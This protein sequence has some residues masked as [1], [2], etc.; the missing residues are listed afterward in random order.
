MCVPLVR[1]QGVKI[2]C[3]D[4]SSSM[5]PYQKEIPAR[6]EYTTSAMTFFLRH[7]VADVAEWSCS[8]ICGCRVMSSSPVPLKTHRVGE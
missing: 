6:G 4:Y 3:G 2:T 1:K 8:R 7:R 5:V